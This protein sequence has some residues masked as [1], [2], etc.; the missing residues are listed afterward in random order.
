MNSPNP[1]AMTQAAR[2]SRIDSGTGRCPQRSTAPSLAVKLPQTKSRGGRKRSS[3]AG[4]ARGLPEIPQAS[5][6]TA[7]NR[8]SGTATV[9]P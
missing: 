8:L 6:A 4:Q 5:N 1:T 2:A 3:S 7:G 9:T